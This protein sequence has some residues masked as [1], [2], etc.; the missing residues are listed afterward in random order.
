MEENKNTQGL[1]LVDR[2]T[3]YS[4]VIPENV[5]RK[6]REWCFQ[7]PT[8]EWSGTLFYS[9]EGSFTDGSLRIVCRDIYVSD[10]GSSTYTEYD[11][12]ADIVTYMDEHDLLDCY[13]GLLHSHNKMAKQF[14]YS[15][16]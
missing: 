2:H 13:Q 16:A 1:L 12:K 11:H 6:I 5:Q 8:R 3:T 10:I 14:I 7:F 9:V 4:M 15:I